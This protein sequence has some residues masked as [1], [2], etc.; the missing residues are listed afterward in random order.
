MRFW[1]LPVVLSSVLMWA[2]AAPFTAA[3][4]DPTRFFSVI[5][6]LP[7]MA[8]ISE[9]GEGVEFAT[10][11][12]RIAQTSALGLVRRADVLAFY[13]ET[14]PQLGWTQSDRAAFVREGEM[15]SIEFE[16][17]PAGLRVRFALAPHKN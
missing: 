7:V 3:H 8:G 16:Q 13:A 17:D 9:D 2:V 12:G 6:D 15:L 5:D 14:L 1:I 11:G 10:A 4:A